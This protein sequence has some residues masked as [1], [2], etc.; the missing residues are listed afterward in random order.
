MGKLTYLD[1]VALNENPDIPDINKVK[2]QDMNEIKNVVN[3]L[4]KTEQSTTDEETY[5]CNYINKIKGKILWTNEN[6]SNSFLPQTVDLD[7]SNYDYYSITYK[8]Q[9]NN[10][11]ALNTGK[12]PVGYGT[13]LIRYFAFTSGRNVDYENGK[14]KF[15]EGYYFANY[16]K[17]A[18]TTENAYCIPLHIVV[19]KEE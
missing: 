4:V 7:L 17:P 1:K 19:Y 12:I 3:G 18:K 8:E 13:K 5:S 2:A 6:P 11:Y 14:L 10:N 16:S 9:N 15:N